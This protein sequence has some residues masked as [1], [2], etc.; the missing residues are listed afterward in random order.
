MKRTLAALL[1]LAS[2]NQTAPVASVVPP[3]PLE[4][5]TMTST[6]ATGETLS[7]DAMPP[8]Y[9]ITVNGKTWSV[10]AKV[11]F[12]HEVKNYN[13]RAIGIYLPSTREILVMPGMTRDETIN[14]IVHEGGHY[15]QHERNLSNPNF[16]ESEAEC[17]TRLHMDRMSVKMVPSITPCN[18]ADENSARALDNYA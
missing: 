7:E 14:V 4:E 17:Y 9:S 11:T 1:L 15:R 12:T 16:S 2:C 8:M 3:V 13:P 18:P 6:N 10:P 5:H